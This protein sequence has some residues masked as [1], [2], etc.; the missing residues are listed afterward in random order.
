MGN[1]SRA[2]K[3]VQAVDRLTESVGRTVSWLTIPVVLA[4]FIAVPLRYVFHYASTYLDDWPQMRTRED[5]A[6]M[7]QMMGGGMMWGMGLIGFLIIVVLILGVAA[8]LKYL[9]SNRQ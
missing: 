1:E 6:M 5:R 8:L 3:F 4:L 2:F 7:D 9:F